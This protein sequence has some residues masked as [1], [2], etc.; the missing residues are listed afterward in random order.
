[1]SPVT[2]LTI[3]SHFLRRTDSSTE[4]APNTFATGRRSAGN[5]VYDVG[6]AGGAVLGLSA[7]D[8]VALKEALPRAVTCQA[9]RTP[10][11]F[12]SSL[13]VMSEV[14][15]TS[16]ELGIRTA[17]HTRQAPGRAQPP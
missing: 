7:C 1:M 4:D 17:V 9:L 12:L 2:S 13:S 11:A 6:I 14:S 15:S 8:L 5:N 16:A 10:S 3:P